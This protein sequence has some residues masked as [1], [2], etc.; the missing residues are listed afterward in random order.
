[1]KRTMVG[2]VAVAFV[3]VAV[4][5]ASVSAQENLEK[6]PSPDQIKY[7]K[8]MKREGNA[9]FGI[10]LQNQKMNSGTEKPP[11]ST[12]VGGKSNVPSDKLAEKLEKIATP[13]VISMYEKI[14]RVGNALWGVKKGDDQEDKAKEVKKPTIPVTAEMATCVAAAIDVKDAALKAVV[15][16]MSASLEA[17][18]TAR[19]TCQKAALQAGENHRSENEVCIKSFHEANKELSKKNREAH[20]N[21]WASY[22]TSLQ[23]CRPASVT[24]GEVMIEDGSQE[25]MEVVSEVVSE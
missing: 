14:R 25:I 1:M 7:F 20:K 8:I 15:S 4:L 13:Q 18:I 23:L 11:V 21:A 9:L 3:A 5:G 17:A 6:V 22:K 19:N 12:S 2:L 16:D 10:R 24:E